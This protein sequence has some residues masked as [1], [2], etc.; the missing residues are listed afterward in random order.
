MIMCKATIQVCSYNKETSA[1]DCAHKAQLTIMHDV[2][3]DVNF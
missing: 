2:M 3:Y 1:S